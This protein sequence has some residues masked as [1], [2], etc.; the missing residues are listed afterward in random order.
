MRLLLLQFVKG[1]IYDQ[2]TRRGAMFIVLVSAMLMV[3]AG[4][5]FLNTALIS[6]PLIFLTYWGVCAWLTFCAILL[7]LYDLLAL[8]RLAREERRRLR[9]E[10]FSKEQKEE[11]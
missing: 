2:N 3:F 11:D 6:R 9:M 8:R 4:G 1:L 10:I 7:A 5:T